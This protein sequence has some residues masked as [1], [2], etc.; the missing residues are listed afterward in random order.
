MKLFC[1]FG[2][3]IKHSISPKLHNSAILGLNLNAMYFKKKIQ[4]KDD[5]KKTFLEYC[6]S[7]ANITVPFK[8]DAFKICDE[9]KG[10][11]NDIKAVN[12]IVLKDKKLIGYNTDANGFFKS[13]N[14]FDIKNALILGAGGSSKAISFILK[15]NNI[16][17]DITNRSK[18]KLNFFTQHN[19]STLLHEQIDTNKKYDL[20]INSTSAGLNDENLPIK[21]E[22]LE[23]LFSNAK[24]AVDII[25]N[26]N[27]PFLNLAKAKNL[28]TKDGKDMLLYQ[29]VL[30]FNIFFDNQYDE[31]TITKFMK[32][33]FI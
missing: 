4:D 7:G 23:K 31:T 17:L 11:A 5:L 6:L 18:E 2:N 15:N 12:T 14:D 13:I 27:T 20:I 29:A 28:I 22:I 33:A 24:Y 19:F 25:Y 26:I 32:K 9:I 16:N 1:V 10:I 3:P 30:A 21:K 8:E